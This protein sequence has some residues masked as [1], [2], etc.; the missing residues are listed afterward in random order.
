MAKYVILMLVSTVCERNYRNNKVF[1]LYS[2]RIII[3]S[4]IPWKPF[5]MLLTSC[6]ILSNFFMTTN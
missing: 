4:P 1:V 2:R 5:V 3:T 6:A